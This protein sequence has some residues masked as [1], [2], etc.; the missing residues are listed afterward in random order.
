MAATTYD[1]AAATAA[2]DDDAVD[3]NLPG[4]SAFTLLVQYNTLQG[5]QDEK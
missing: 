4:V 1:A 3:A 5:N 2:A